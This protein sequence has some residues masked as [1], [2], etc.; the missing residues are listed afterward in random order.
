[1]LHSKTS[2]N[3]YHYLIFLIKLI[4]VPMA[5]RGPPWAFPL[6][7]VKMFMALGARVCCKYE[8]II[9][10]CQR[11]DASEIA[12]HLQYAN[13]RFQLKHRRVMV[14]NC[15]TSWLLSQFV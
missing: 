5:L 11:H 7:P 10:M 2:I 6:L 1:M 13:K 15:R 12:I 3:H 4:M 9:I 14:L 8:E